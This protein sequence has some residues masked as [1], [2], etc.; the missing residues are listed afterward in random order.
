MVRPRRTA[1]KSIGHQPA[2]QMAPRDVPP[3]PEPQP[4]SPEYVPQEEDSFE[5][6]VMVP[7]RE[8]TQEA[9]QL[10]QN[11]NHDNN[12]E[13]E[14]DNETKEEEGDDGEDEDDEDYTPLSD[15]EKEKMYHEADEIK[16]TRNEALIP[17][18]KLQDFLN[19][20]DITT[21]L[22]FRIK[23]VLCPGR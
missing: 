12:H 10:P 9:Q 16:T 2:G 17:T 22:E 19:C 1:R 6:V 23:R 21:P 15:S 4:N 5:I 20:I 18:D 8:D 11:D 7:A 3:Q 14:E 13:E